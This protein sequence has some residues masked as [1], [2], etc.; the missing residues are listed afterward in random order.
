MTSKP[1]FIY[2]LKCA[3]GS[4]YTGISTDVHRRFEE[5]QSQGEKCAK[6]LRGKA[7]LKL[8]YIEEAE[9]RSLATQREMAIKKLSRL[10]KQR[11]IETYQKVEES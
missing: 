2:M 11:L 4:L 5:H 8:M 9:D 6:F 3:N 1:W 10:Q 7:P